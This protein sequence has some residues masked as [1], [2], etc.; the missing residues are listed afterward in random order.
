MIAREKLQ[1]LS[2]IAVYPSP[3]RMI[4]D[5]VQKKN[6]FG[7]CINDRCDF[8]TDVKLGES[9]AYCE[10]CATDSVVSAL[11]LADCEGINA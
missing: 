6:P 5:I 9:R 3:R 7:I 11:V 8:V 2:E 4:R 10:V 1:R